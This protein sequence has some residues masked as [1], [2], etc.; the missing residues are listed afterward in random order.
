MSLLRVDLVVP[1]FVVVLGEMLVVTFLM[2][3]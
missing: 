3:G 1:L 2:W